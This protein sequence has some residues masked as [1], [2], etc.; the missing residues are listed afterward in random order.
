MTHCAKS[1]LARNKRRVVGWVV[2]GRG[3]GGLVGAAGCE[4]E[5]D[6]LGAAE[7]GSACGLAP[8]GKPLCDLDEPLVLFGLEGFGVDEVGGLRGAFC[9]VEPCAEWLKDLGERGSHRW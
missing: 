2:G 5:R 8:F 9:G 6:Q 7:V 4:T 1:A 3:G